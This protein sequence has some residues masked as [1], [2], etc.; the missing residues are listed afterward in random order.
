VG[1]WYNN[2]TTLGPRQADVAAWCAR[3]DRHA[4]VTP[5]RGGI[6]V[7]FDRDVDEAADPGELG[8]L[9]VVASLELSC[10]VLAAAVYDDDVLLLALYDAGRQLGEYSS[11]RRS[12]LT[13]LTLCRVFGVPRYAPIV[14]L[15][16]NCPRLPLFLFESVRHRLL[17][18]V[19]DQPPWA[20]A[21]GYRYIRK[22]EPP[23][24]L[25][26]ADLLF[27]DGGRPPE[28]AT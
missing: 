6:T 13:A 14:W 9:A 18:R 20:V 23:S 25:E 5:T 8:D 27:I 1:N 21:S 2:V 15:V 22:G 26:L 28:G 12:T 24:A 11:A 10:P 3:H 4:Y 7:L 16:L 19:L 17:L